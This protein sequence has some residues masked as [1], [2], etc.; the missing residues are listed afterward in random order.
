MVY[1][2]HSDGGVRVGSLDILTTTEERRSQ[3]IV[4]L[5]CLGVSKVFPV[6]DEGTSWRIVFGSPQGCK[7]V[8]A[9]DNVSLCVPK[10]KVIGILGRNGA[11]KSTLLRILAG[12]YRP[13]SGSIQPNGTV[14]GLFELGGLGKG[15]LTGREYAERFL[16][17]HLAQQSKLPE[18]MEEIHEFSE[19]GAK[20]EKPIYTLSTGMAARLYFATATAL[21]YDIY[22]ID[23]VLAVGDEHFQGRCWARL[24]ERLSHGA[25][26]VLVTHDWTAILKLCEVSHIVDRGRIIE[27]GPTE[28]IVRSYLNLRNDLSTHVARFCPDTPTDY[29]AHCQ[30]DAEIRFLVEL[31]KPEPVELGYSIELLRA[32]I[33]WEILLL[34]DH[35]PIASSV[36]QHEVR[37][38]IPRLPLP[39]GRYYLNLFLNAVREGPSGRRIPCDARSWTHGSA[40]SLT[41]EGEACGSATMVPLNWTKNDA[42]R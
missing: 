29:F 25:S 20:F 23:E 16:R 34:A 6:L 37:L 10:G 17:F 8:T 24:R 18:L 5:A 12:V 7:S 31:N 22:L 42:I 4:T 28:Q 21:K 33:C 41:V 13:T 19:L 40:L 36:G 27:S 26:G 9:L 38:K 39:P 32:G 30:Q 14:S 15:H 2:L 35:L 3:A 1:E 11:G